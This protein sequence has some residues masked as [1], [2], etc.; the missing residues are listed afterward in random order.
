MCAILLR[1]FPR[2]LDVAN[3]GVRQRPP[4]LLDE[5]LYGRIYK[6]GFYSKRKC[7]GLGHF[8]LTLREQYLCRQDRQPRSDCATPLLRC[9]AVHFDAQVRQ[10]HVACPP[11]HNKRA[12]PAFA[13]QGVEVVVGR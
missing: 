8:L 6:I 11:I 4:Y 5:A 13:A 7:H 9:A 3:A 2:V 10:G 1:R 12:K